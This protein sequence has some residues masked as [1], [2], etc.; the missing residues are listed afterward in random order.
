MQHVH[1]Q[2]YWT[3]QRI[4]ARNAYYT[5]VL[6]HQGSDITKYQCLTTDVWTVSS[7]VNQITVSTITHSM[8]ADTSG[9]AANVTPVCLAIA[10]SKQKL[11]VQLCKTVQASAC[12]PPNVS[13]V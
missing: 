7:L 5:Y 6:T 8:Q 1:I 12:P 13:T 4:S 9:R 10:T 11:K 2:D 3:I